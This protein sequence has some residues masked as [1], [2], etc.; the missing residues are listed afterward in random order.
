MKILSQNGLIGQT[1]SVVVSNTTVIPTD[2]PGPSVLERLDN[3][4]QRHLQSA[5]P[6]IEQQWNVQRTLTS[7]TYIS[8]EALTRLK[9]GYG[10]NSRTIF[11]SA[12]ST[13][14]NRNGISIDFL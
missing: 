13:S 7:S 10:N 6:A 2:P 8:R 5:V 1:G 3:F 4:K 14:F 9:Q 11:V 12:P